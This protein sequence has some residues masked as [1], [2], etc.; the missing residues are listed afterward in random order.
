MA[1][2]ALSSH[3]TILYWLWKKRRSSTQDLS[4][5]FSPEW[6]QQS[7]PSSVP[8]Y[9]WRNIYKCLRNEEFICNIFGFFFFHFVFSAWGRKGVKKDTL[10]SA[11]MRTQNLKIEGHTSSPLPWGRNCFHNIT[12]WSA[13]FKVFTARE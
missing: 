8:F 6:I 12:G 7:M 13:T 5:A 2:G 3:L 9:H 1:F 10:N 4:I 11:K